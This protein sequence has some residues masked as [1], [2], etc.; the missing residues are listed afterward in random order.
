MHDLIVPHYV[1]KP[2]D[3]VVQYEQASLYG[4]A[5]HEYLRKLSDKL[6]GMGGDDLHI[7]NI[8][9]ATKEW[10]LA[11]D[12]R[13]LDP[14]DIRKCLILL[15]ECGGMFP[16]DQAKILDIQ[17]TKKLS[18][19]FEGAL[20][21]AEELKRHFSI[22]SRPLLAGIIGQHPL[23]TTKESIEEAYH[24]WMGGCDLVMEA[25]FLKVDNPQAFS[26]RL[27]FMSK[28]MTNCSRRTQMTKSYVP[29]I[30]GASIEDIS[31]KLQ[32]AEKY[33]ISIVQLDEKS[34][35]LSGIKSLRHQF[36]QRG[37]SL[38]IRPSYPADYHEQL[39]LEIL[40]AVG[41]DILDISHIKAFLQSQVQSHIKKNAE[42]KHQSGIHLRL[43]SDYHA[44]EEALKDLTELSILSTRSLII[45]HPDG[46]KQG[47]MACLQALDAASKGITQKSVSNSAAALKK[48]LSTQEKE[49]ASKLVGSL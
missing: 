9:E 16:Y 15:E 17:W 20:N 24:M 8:N 32:K 28:E 13:L 34:V 37:L 42:R 38:L 26:E 46:I 27:E 21:G 23:T 30:S 48:A 7:F 49:S 19:S 41:A 29:Y 6:H 12:E 40:Q 14:T 31:I 5:F 10:S 35:G 18:S 11:L 36:G 22:K 3:L 2:T 47:A 39:H 4:E 44:I 25:P 1:S 43:E 45:K 33:G